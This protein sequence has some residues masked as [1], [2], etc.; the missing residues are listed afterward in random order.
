MNENA[1]EVL[2]GTIEYNEAKRIKAA[3]SEKGIEL[4][5][6]GDSTACASKSC[7]ISLQV[8][9]Q[10]KDLPLVREFL[11][12]EQQKVFEGLDFDPN[13][14]NEVFDPEQ[15]QARC[16]A[17]GTSFKTSSTSCPDCGLVFVPTESE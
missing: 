11:I 12:A 16:P 13:I 17:C 15:E 4:R 1:E 7:R 10:T 14:I 3:L 9:S 6:A 2:I 8:F 5:L